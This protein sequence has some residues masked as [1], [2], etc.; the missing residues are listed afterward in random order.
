VV[1]ERIGG[2]AEVSNDLVPENYR[3]RRA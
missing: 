3:M 1:A 2:A